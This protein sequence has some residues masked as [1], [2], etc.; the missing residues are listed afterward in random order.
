MQSRN[1]SHFIHVNS[2]RFF[3]LTNA[4][5]LRKQNVTGVKWEQ[6][7]HEFSAWA[8]NCVLLLFQILDVNIILS[9]KVWWGFTAKYQ[10]TLINPTSCLLI[11][12]ETWI[13]Q[14]FFV[15]KNEDYNLSKLAW[16]KELWLGCMS[17]S[18]VWIYNIYLYWHWF[19]VFKI[20]WAF[21]WRGLTI[22]K[23]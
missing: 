18:S 22:C 20:A 15:Y 8:R 1:Q 3:S 16:N 23:E 9:G 6:N 10:D 11:T 5:C 4:F 17:S 7:D 2:F 14:A 12:M 19:I 13:T 21:S